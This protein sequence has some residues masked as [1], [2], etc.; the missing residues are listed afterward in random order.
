M[1][2]KR[3]RYFELT[4]KLGDCQSDQHWNGFRGNADENV[5]TLDLALMGFPERIHIISKLNGAEPN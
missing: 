2:R 1:G 4:T 3:K 5:H